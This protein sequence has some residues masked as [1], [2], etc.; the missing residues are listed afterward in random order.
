MYDESRVT[1][2]YFTNLGG[3]TSN[4]NFPISAK[5]SEM[6][7]CRGIS[8][9]S[10]KRIKTDIELVPDGLA[11]EQVNKLEA[12]YYNYK[13]PM[14]KKEKKVIGFIAQET[15]DVIPNAVNIINEYIP[16]E[17]RVIENPVWS[18]VNNKW[19]LTINDISFTDA[20][21]GNCKFNV[22]TDC[23]NSN[24]ETK[25]VKIEDDNKTFIFDNKYQNIGLWGKEVND[26]HTIDKNMIFALHH[27]AIQELS[28]ENDKKNRK[29]IE[30]ENENTLLKRAYQKNRRKIR[31]IIIIYLTS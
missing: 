31:F 22:M 14:K 17:L 16:D 1:S 5:L 23:S 15:K 18:N 6:L 7:L 27:S 11:L 8:I 26:F 24:I 13:D 9:Y 4:A 2:N 20:H 21:T 28:R 12:K 10:D 29:I 19:H 3:L 30:L 25:I